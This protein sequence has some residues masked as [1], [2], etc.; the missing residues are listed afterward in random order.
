MGK[1]KK[2]HIVAVEE[3]D[4]NAT[5]AHMGLFSGI[6]MIVGLMVG[7]GI[8]A[9]ASPSFKKTGS[10]GV[11]LCFWALSGLLSTLGALCY[12]ELGCAIPKSGIRLFSPIFINFLIR[13][14]T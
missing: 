2:E 3:P 5:K 7:A 12:V 11:T 1:E 8:F 4:E 9:T 13:W 10:V 14:R 6:S